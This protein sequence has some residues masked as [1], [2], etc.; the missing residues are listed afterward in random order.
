MWKKNRVEYGKSDQKKGN[1][2]EIE[3]NISEKSRYP[4]ESGKLRG[5]LKFTVSS[6]FDFNMHISPNCSMFE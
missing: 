3:T 5:D 4:W 1:W 2:K 6:I